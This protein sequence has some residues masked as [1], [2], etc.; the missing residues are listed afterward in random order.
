MLLVLHDAA[1]LTVASFV[2][3]QG[4]FRC[5]SLTQTVFGV[6]KLL[7]DMSR[8]KGLRFRNAWVPSSNPGL[9]HHFFNQFCPTPSGLPSGRIRM[10]SQSVSICDP[11]GFKLPGGVAKE[12]HGRVRL[13]VSQLARSTD[14]ILKVSCFDGFSTKLT[15]IDAV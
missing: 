1:L 8:G 5:S 3:V 12:V 9:Q 4:D 2:P 14:R 7:I 11:S 15:L 10:R 6:R 13:P